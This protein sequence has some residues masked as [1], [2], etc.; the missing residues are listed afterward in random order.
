MKKLLWSLSA[1]VIY[2]IAYAV[3]VETH[4]PSISDDYGDPVFRSSYP[5]V[6]QGAIKNMGFTM[7]FQKVGPA[8]YIFHPI[9]QCWRSIRGLSPSRIT[10]AES[11]WAEYFEYKFTCGEMKRGR[12]KA[13]S[14]P[15]E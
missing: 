1:L 4:W 2:V 5:K 7:V 8:N 13:E 9:D 12:S 14:G 3:L 15:R 11:Y 6:S 10:N